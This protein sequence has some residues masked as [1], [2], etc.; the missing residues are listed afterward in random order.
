MSLK[1][2]RCIGGR[3]Q[4]ALINLQ[5]SLVFPFFFFFQQN[6]FFN[7]AEKGLRFFEE[8]DTNYGKPHA[9]H[10]S[11]NDYRRKNYSS[12]ID[13]CIHILIKKKHPLNAHTPNLPYM[14]LY[15]DPRWMVR[16]FFFNIETIFYRNRMFAIHLHSKRIRLL[17]WLFC[18]TRFDEN[19][20]HVRL[21]GFDD[22]SRICC[23]GKM[24]KK[25]WKLWRIIDSCHFTF[26]A[27]KL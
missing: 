16:G 7:I 4:T 26:L 27:R 21:S 22:Y 18:S 12:V 17:Q 10:Y 9:R 20:S 24:L 19:T 1:F 23:F 6:T 8:F 5:I 3:P 13:M 25:T 14:Q 2:S 15:V 11:E